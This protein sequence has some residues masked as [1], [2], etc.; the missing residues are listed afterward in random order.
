MAMTRICNHFIVLFVFVFFIFVGLQMKDFFNHEYVRANQVEKKR[1]HS[2]YY[3]EYLFD[4]SQRKDKVVIAVIGSSVTKGS[5]ASILENNWPTQ[6][7]YALH[8][9]GIRNIKLINLGFSR[10]KAQDLLAKGVITE[11]S[12][13]QPDLIIFETSVINNYR[14]ATTM[15]HTIKYID[16]LLN[17]I[18][19]ELPDA[20]LIVISPNPILSMKKN[21][22]GFYYQDYL[23]QSEKYVREKGYDYLN[24]YEGMNEYIDNENGSLTEYLAD[25]IHPNDRGYKLWS[26]LLMDYMKNGKISENIW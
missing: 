4:L 26:K 5:G 23:E 15:E 21:K 24:I 25:E 22:I 14:Q 12:K 20:K 8:R 6:L 2:N 1:H 3:L 18:T 7:L 11:L 10:F 16:I 9:E 17:K 19:K 13:Q